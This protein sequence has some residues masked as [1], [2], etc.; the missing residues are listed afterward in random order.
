MEYSLAHSHIDPLV[1]FAEECP[2]FLDVSGFKELQEL[3]DV[4]FGRRFNGFVPQSAL[5]TFSEVL[6]R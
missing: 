6:E 5:F 2:G 3:L 4:R 1:D